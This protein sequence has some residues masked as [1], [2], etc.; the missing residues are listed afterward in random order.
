MSWSGAR[1]AVALGL[2]GWLSAWPSGGRAQTTDSSP[3]VAVGSPVVAEPPGVTEP[4]AVA[5]PPGVTEPPAVA[6]PPTV[7]G[8]SGVIAP[9][10]VGGPAP[11]IESPLGRGYSQALFVDV[12]VGFVPYA[13][14][15]P[16]M[17]G[18]GIRF[19]AIHELWA[20]VGFIIGVGDDRGHTFGSAGYRVALRP[21]RRVRP[22]VGGLVAGLNATCTHDALGQPSCTPTPLFIFAATGGVRIEPVPWLGLFG[23]LTFGTDT[24]PNPFGMIELGV[25][26]ALPQ[27]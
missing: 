7:V 12:T 21:G 20:R 10:G 8:P 3:S 22:L 26:F 5:G 23:V 1:G 25:S 11:V 19:A 15:A 2:C 14:D 24:Y 4:P 27:S 18:A 9:P 6:G 17:L 16:L 13:N